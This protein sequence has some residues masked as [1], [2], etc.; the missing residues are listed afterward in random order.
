MLLKQQKR[1][2]VTGN[3]TTSRCLFHAGRCRAADRAP[4][5]GKSLTLTV[6]PTA[7][8]AAEHCILTT[9]S[10]SEQDGAGRTAL[11]TARYPHQRRR[12]GQASPPEQQATQQRSAAPARLKNTSGGHLAP[13]ATDRPRENAAEHRAASSTADSA[14]PQ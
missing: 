3:S 2:P 5:A 10:S 13:P 4:A 9:T 8:P 7:S 1:A 6:T 12:T 14:R 11:A